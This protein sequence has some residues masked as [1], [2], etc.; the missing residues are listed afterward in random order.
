MSGRLVEEL[1][2]RAAL[3]MREVFEVDADPEVRPTNDP[4]FGDYQINGVLPLARRIGGNP[5]QLATRL[6]EGLDL[7]DMCLPPEIA[8][9]GFI[10]L[11]LDPFWVAREA[12]RVA[13]DPRANISPVQAPQCVVVDF[14]SPN[15]A[16]RMH[17][18]HLRSTIIGDALVRTLRFLGHRVVGD[19]HVGDWG[20]QFG[21][22][23]WAWERHADQA[24]LDADPIGE[25]E[26]LYKLGSEAAKADPQVAD[27]CRAELAAL[28]AGDPERL[29]LW[30]RFVAISRADAEAIYARLG[31]SF[32]TWHGESFYHERLA[33]V[34]ERLCE[35]G[36][37]R[38][39][40]GA[41]AVFFDEDG[42]L[43]GTPLLVQKSDGA[44]LYATSDVATA[45][46]RIETYA[47]DRIVYVVDVRQSLHFKQLFAT[48]EALGYDQVRFEHVGFGMMLG[49]DGRPFRTRDGGT[50]TLAALLEEAEERILPIVAEKWPDASEDEQRDIAR[51]V[52]YG[53]VKYAD[54]S[55]NLTTD[56]RFD[57]DKF[58]AAEGNTGPYLQYALVRIRS[59][60]REYEVRVGRPFVADGAPLRLEA[61]QER[62]LATE[63]LKLGDALDS[64]ARL[65]RPHIVCEYLFGVARRFSPF[66][67]ACPILG[68]PDE[69]LRDSRVA[70]AVATA[71]TLEIGLDCLN[72]PLLDR[73]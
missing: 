1:T 38:E 8:G 17:V 32:D 57:W 16:K 54:L 2:R 73:M 70:L 64:A 46:Y 51:R 67:A 44:Y 6:L 14:S 15:V 33:G 3:A 9:P 58:L 42:D 12:G 69:G 65:S 62:E 22:L 49:A 26:R 11:R 63:L 59:V 50:V 13:S 60:L 4:R 71:R 43:G 37:A 55:Q 27:A 56:Y 39:S 72:I 19:N 41:I 36:L 18:G 29:A 61:D 30:K 34:V 45:E 35:R 28:Q 40:E 66:Y 52:G 20:T 68:A 10:N 5:R 53:A 31:V 21:I 47:P 24:A 23:L 7:G 25:L 48:L